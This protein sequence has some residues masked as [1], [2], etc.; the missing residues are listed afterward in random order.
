MRTVSVIVPTYKEAEN[1]PHLAERLRAVFAEW[2]I[3]PEVLLMDDNSNDGSI[4]AVEALNLDW[5]NIVVRTKDR[6]LS[7][8]VLDGLRRAKGD[9]A[10]V[11]DADLSHPPEILPKLVEALDNGADFAIG[12][13]YVKGGSTDVEWS[14][15]RRVNS[16]G[17]TIMAR[18][19][20]KV[21]DPMSGFFAIRPA[22]MEN[23]PYLNPV[24]YKIA[25]ELIVKCGCKK[26]AE[27]PIHFAD[28][29][30]GE[31]KLT[32]AEQLRYIQHLRRLY[33]FKYAEMSHLAQFL[34][35]GATGTVVNLLVL[36]LALQF[37]MAARPAIAVAILVSM[38]SNFLLNRRFTFSYARHGSVMRQFSGYTAASFLGAVVN[39]GVASGTLTIWPELLPHF[40]SLAGIAV[41][42][43]VNFAMNR[44]VVFSKSR[45][46]Q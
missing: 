24:G 28:R 1:I 11:M 18:P 13:R 26:V 7:Q 33:I 32:L 42:T 19:L 21:S 40:A 35:V 5:F 10:I 43:G 31:S 36:T 41:G 37:G 8:S 16:W 30:M 14:F 44:L 38:V 6:G 23:A 17:A 29:M 27:V 22:A 2:D 34:F 45:H 20:T 3:E 46:Q 9:V 15:L 39:F 4:E 12:S 25:L